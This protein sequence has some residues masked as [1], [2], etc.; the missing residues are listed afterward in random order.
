MSSLRHKMFYTVLTLSYSLHSVSEAQ[1]GYGLYGG[2]QKCNTQFKIGAGAQSYLDEYRELQSQVKT[3]QAEINSKKR[4]LRTAEVDVRRMKFAMQRTLNADALDFVTTHSEEQRRCSDYEGMPK[5]I[6]RAPRTAQRESDVVYEQ[7]YNSNTGTVSNSG[8]SSGDGSGTGVRRSTTT[9]SSNSSSTDDSRVVT[10]MRPSSGRTQSTTNSGASA[11]SGNTG[12]RRSTTVNS[13]SG[14]A[15]TGGRSGELVPASGETQVRRADSSSGG[16]EVRRSGNSTGTSENS[17][18]EMTGVRRRMQ[19]RTPQSVVERGPSSEAA[20]A[21]DGSSEPE[22]YEIPFGLSVNEFSRLCP[23]GRRELNGSAVCSD[24]RFLMGVAKVNKAECSNAVSGYGKKYADTQ[25]LTK[26]IESQQELLATYSQQINEVKMAFT[27]EINNQQT[28]QTE[29]GVCIDCMLNSSGYDSAEATPK[30]DWG[31]VAANV[32]TGL[33]ATAS[34][35][36]IE[37][38]RQDYNASIGAA[39][40]W[41][42]SPISYGFPFLYAGLSG[43]LGSGGGQGSF[44]CASTMSGGGNFNGPMGMLGMSGN[45]SMMG[46][47]AGNSMWG[48]PAWANAG[49]AGA[50]GGGIFTPGY[51]P[52]GQNGPWGLNN[53]GVGVFPQVGGNFGGQFGFSNPSIGGAGCINGFAGP[54][55]NSSYGGGVAAGIP[56]SGIN[57]YFPGS[58]PFGAGAGAGFGGAGGFP[59]AGGALGGSVFG[60]ANPFGTANPFNTGAGGQFGMNNPFGG[61]AGNGSYYPGATGFNGMNGV[62]NPQLFQNQI[63]QYNQYIQQQQQNLQMYNQYIQQQQQALQVEAQ[64]QQALLAMQQELEGFYKRYNSIVGSGSGSMLGGAGVGGYTGYN[65][66]M[67]GGYFG[68]GGQLGVGFGAGAGFGGSY[69][70]SPIGAPGGAP[71]NSG[72]TGSNR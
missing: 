37:K 47:Y 62:P 64:K 55:C 44:G 33:F 5:G 43:A 63:S 26:Y 28:S 65:P 9:T 32:L 49:A 40:E 7:G 25:A 57:G 39:S 19:Q 61:V 60:G 51:T 22:K 53:N 21:S 67:G 18:S 8:S 52:W 48:Q 15:T 6:V 46:P 45:G 59:G 70:G 12:V 20:D 4:E 41:S 69:I 35:Y 38:S 72:G 56:G 54:I 11:N 68:A 1:W 2:S 30:K 31:G 24:D 27:E 29:G 71:V 34:A 10:A 66:L 42:P 50:L 17:N 16:T 23:P 36:K 58:S 13:N 14:S 3:I